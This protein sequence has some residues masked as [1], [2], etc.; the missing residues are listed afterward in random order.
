MQFDDNGQIFSIGG[1]EID[2]HIQYQ[3]QLN[4]RIIPQSL[5]SFPVQSNDTITVELFTPPFPRVEVN[6]ETL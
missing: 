5:L 2:D 6:E 3:L 4:G 1:V